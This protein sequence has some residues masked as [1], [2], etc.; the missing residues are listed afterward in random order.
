MSLEAGKA[1]EGLNLRGRPWSKDEETQLRQL[2][3]EGR[4]FDEI[5]SIMGKSRLSVKGKLFNSGLNSVV[6]ATHAQRAVATTVATTI[7]T[8]T[9]TSLASTGPNQSNSR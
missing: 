1:L 3:K 5:S 8:T 9:T 6:V 7:A 4:S 2:V